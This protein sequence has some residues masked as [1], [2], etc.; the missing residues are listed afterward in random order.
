MFILVAKLYLYSSPTM[1]NEHIILS[2][3]MARLSSLMWPSTQ[4]LRW[5]G[6]PSV[7]ILFSSTSS[8]KLLEKQSKSDIHLP[9][10]TGNDFMLVIWKNI[11]N[12]NSESSHPNLSTVSEDIRFS[13]QPVSINTFTCCPKHCEHT[14]KV[15]AKV[16]RKIYLKY[17]KYWWL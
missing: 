10:N 5:N 7:S 17:P 3:P 13:L 16:N 8:F 6:N 9:N 14:K 2:C 12:V 11:K 1:T 15:E 4:I